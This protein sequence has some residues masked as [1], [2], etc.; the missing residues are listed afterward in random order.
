MR[1]HLE[2]VVF[3]L[4]PKLGKGVCALVD[5]DEG[6][7]SCARC[8]GVVGEHRRVMLRLNER[9]GAEAEDV[10]LVRSNV[11]LGFRFLSQQGRVFC[12]ISRG[13]IIVKEYRILLLELEEEELAESSIGKLCHSP[14]LLQFPVLLLSLDPLQLL[15]QQLHH[16]LMASCSCV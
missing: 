5:E 3:V 15:L 2:G 9:C 8:S 13:D 12:L 7:G 10:K 14:L 11:A 4:R 6:S 16:S 1:A